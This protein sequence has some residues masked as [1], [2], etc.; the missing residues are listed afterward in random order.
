MAVGS[1]WYQEAADV[2]GSIGQL[3]A[4]LEGGSSSNSALQSGITNARGS[5]NQAYS[6]AAQYQQ[7][8]SDVGKTGLAGQQTIANMAAPQSNFQYNYQQDPAYQNQ[9]TAGNQNIQAQ[10]SSMGQLFSGSTL[11]ALSQYGSNL[12]NQSYNQNYNRAFDTYTNQR[13]FDEQALLNKYAQYQGLTNIGQA[14]ANNLTGLQTQLGQGNANLDLMSGNANAG[15]QAQKWNTWGNF[16]TNL[17]SI[18]NG[19][20]GQSGGQNGQASSGQMGSNGLSSLFK[21]I[22]NNGSSSGSDT[23]NISVGNDFTGSDMSG[24]E[25]ST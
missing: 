7:P 9:L 1:S 2:G 17:T 4:G 15:Q 21:N 12:A 20:S 24:G 25:A 19:N 18:G 23:D 11:K 22:F 6:N 10:A 16:A 5:L 8:Y 13:N 3:I 14:A